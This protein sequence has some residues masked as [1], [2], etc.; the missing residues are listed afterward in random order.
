[1]KRIVILIACVAIASAYNDC[2]VAKDLTYIYDI[3]DYSGNYTAG[4]EYWMRMDTTCTLLVNVN[5]KLTWYS[6]DIS[7][8]Y[9]MYNDNNDGAGCRANSTDAL[10]YIEGH[11]ID[12]G[13]TKG[14]ACLVKYFI[15]NKNKE[16]DL[17]V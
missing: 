8:K 17:R 1:M 13:P 9:L 14:N 6:S 7:A 3:P 16:H 12:L 10:S 2:M 15:T 11:P 5:S 4:Y